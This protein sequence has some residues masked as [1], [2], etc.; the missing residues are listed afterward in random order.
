MP[1]FRIEPDQDIHVAL[2]TEVI[3]QHGAEQRQLQDLP[4]ITQVGYRV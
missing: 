4:S 2:G 3:T 1:R